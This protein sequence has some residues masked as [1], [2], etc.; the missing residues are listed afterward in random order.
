MRHTVREIRYSDKILR[1]LHTFNMSF[2]G[3]YN[4]E[5]N[6]QNLFKMSYCITTI[7]KY[8]AEDTYTL[9]PWYLCFR[10]LTKIIKA[11]LQLPSFKEVSLSTQSH[12]EALS[13][14]PTECIQGYYISQ[15]PWACIYSIWWYGCT[16]FQVNQ[17]SRSPSKII[18]SIV[19]PFW[20]SKTK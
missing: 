1:Y 7:V 9:D 20:S 3:L 17:H 5:M 18:K 10:L 12:E 6:T 8:L 2:V 14:Q 11:V 15:Q 19:S 13:P 16:L 4:E